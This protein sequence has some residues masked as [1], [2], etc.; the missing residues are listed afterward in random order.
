MFKKIFV[1][2]AGQMGVGISQV[3]AMAGYQV[4]LMDKQLTA[5]E[6]GKKQ[7][8]VSTQKLVQKD[9]MPTKALTG[10]EEM[11]LTTDLQAAAESD[12]VIEAVSECIEVKQQVFV[13]LNDICKPSCIFA[14][15]TSSIPI[16]QLASFTNRAQQFIGLHFMNPVPLMQLVEVISG[17]HTAG[18]VRDQCEQFILSLNKK[19]CHAQDYPGFIVNRILM[20]MINEAFNTLMEQVG[21]AEDIDLAMRLG[22]HQPMG[23]LALA[24]FIGLDTCLAIMNVLY[25]GFK[26]PRY[27]PSPLLIKYVSS[28]CLGRKTGAGVFAYSEEDPAVRA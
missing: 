26:D 28:G 11:V 16:T 22:T 18:E 21:S 6:N 19:S 14:S 4:C 25:E 5:C 12:L 7:A 3:C 17:H 13:Q 24:D 23:P 15:N 8:W 2:G 20:P 1:V 27:R 10:V 9:K